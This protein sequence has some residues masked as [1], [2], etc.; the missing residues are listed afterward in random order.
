MAFSIEFFS[1]ILISDFSFYATENKNQCMGVA[2]KE[3]DGEVRRKQNSC[4][5]I[6]MRKVYFIL[7]S[8]STC[9]T[10]YVD[11]TNS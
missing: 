8:D 2:E 1:F 5:A 10:E 3:R 7:P 9:L 11:F 4:D 6:R